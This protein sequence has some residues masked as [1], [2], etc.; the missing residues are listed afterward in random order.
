MAQPS[1]AQL[2]FPEDDPTAL[3]PYRHR[4]ETF[5]LKNNS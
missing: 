4:G 5:I 3:V 2:A 1:G